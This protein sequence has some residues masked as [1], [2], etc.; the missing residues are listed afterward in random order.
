V[1]LKDSN[2]I[3]IHLAPYPIVARVRLPTGNQDIAEI[4]QREVS[5][6]QYLIEA[7][8]PVTSPSFDLP[9]G[10]HFHEGIGL[11]FW[12]FI[13]HHP[14]DE[15]DSRVAAEALRIVHEALVSYEAE[16]PSYTLAIE[17]CQALLEDRSKLPALAPNDRDF[18]LKQSHRFSTQLDKFSFTPMALHGDCHLGNALM[19]PS[20]A[21][22]TDFE[23]VCRGPREWDL[24]CLSE[25]VLSIFP[26]VNR[27]LYDVLRDLR[28]FCV[29]VW[30]WVDPN[31]SPD[32]LEAAE[33]HLLR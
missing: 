22:W 23:S 24:T 11:T 12:Q 14:V 29:A 5:V 15:W 6:A 28:S 30:C 27:E 13:E 26:F 10:P 7:K 25:E 32:K 20:G 18:L 1:L 33:Y 19:A 4:L 8:A 21:V 3:S 17:S 31:R 9:P 2:H 16:L